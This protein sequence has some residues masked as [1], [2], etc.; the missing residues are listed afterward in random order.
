MRRGRPAVQ[1]M[2]LGGLG[3]GV[4]V[5][6]G[7][8]SLHSWDETDSRKAEQGKDDIWWQTGIQEW[9]SFYSWSLSLQLDS[10]HART[11]VQSVGQFFINRDVIFIESTA[12]ASSKKS[13][14]FSK[15]CCCIAQGRGLQTQATEPHEALLSLYC[16]SLVLKKN[17]TFL[18]RQYII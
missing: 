18:N 9:Q 2:L 5:L 7:E 12:I 4:F 16:C 3:G 14:V 10:E 13:T 8:Q 1:W 11:S 17:D 15:K 6:L